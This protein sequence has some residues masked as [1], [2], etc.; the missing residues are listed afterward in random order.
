MGPAR[1]EGGGEVRASR[2]VVARS[3]F[4]S[5]CVRWLA[6]T[7]PRHVVALR[8]AVL[9]HRKTRKQRRRRAEGRES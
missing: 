1:E 4:Q 7:W 3:T 5:G 8:E 6:S 2:G 9:T